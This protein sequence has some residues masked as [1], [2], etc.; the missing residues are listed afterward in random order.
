MHVILSSPLLIEDGDFNRK[1]I[2]RT[3]A[4]TWVD[5]NGP[6]NFSQHETVKILGVEPASTRE[7]TIS[8]DEALVISPQKRLEFGREYTV[9]EIEAIGVNFVLI[10]KVDDK[11]SDLRIVEY[12]C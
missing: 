8:Y 9:K 2:T 7:E 10:T 4:Q 11:P 5:E 6:I 1:T 12:A 3:E